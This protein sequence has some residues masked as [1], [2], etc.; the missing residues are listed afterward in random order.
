MEIGLGLEN[1]LDWPYAY[2]KI[3]ASNGVFMGTT[4]VTVNSDATLQLAEKIRGF[5][6]NIDDEREFDLGTVRDDENGARLLFHCIDRQGHAAVR[7][8]IQS[9]QWFSPALGNATFPIPIEPA[10]IDRFIQELK[11]MTEKP[12]S[13]AYLIG[14]KKAE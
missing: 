4:L 11:Q 10:A 7:V 1:I 13:R 6:N 5:P 12:G 3:S 2:L 8:T 9:S 14:I